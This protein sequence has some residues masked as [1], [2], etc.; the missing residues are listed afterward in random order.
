MLLTCRSGWSAYLNGAFIGSWLGSTKI[1]KG[2]V[3]LSFANATLNS[4]SSN[5]LFII[6]DHMGKDQTSGATNP[7]GIFNA[8]IIGGGNFSSWK[9]AGKAGGDKNIDPVRGPYAEGGLHA[10]RLG[11]HLPGFDDSA[12]DTGS[13][14][15]SLSTAGAK[16]YRTVVPLDLPKGV[17]ASLGFVLSSPAGSKLR[18][19]LYVNGYM[20]AK[21]IPHI[22]NQVT[23]PGKSS[24]PCPCE[25]R[26]MVS[27]SVSWNFGLSWRQYLRP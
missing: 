24:T 23:F 1:T 7:R 26:L 12:W 20:F 3:Q 22:G 13:P 11:W 19:Q 17:D 25:S 9:V 14:A 21:Y 10:E 6:Q 2:E 5:V 8:T 27:C 16:F 15:T 18:A 4:N